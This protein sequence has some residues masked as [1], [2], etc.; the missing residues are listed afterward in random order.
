M[1]K[2][3]RWIFFALLVLVGVAGWY[4]YESFIPKTAV[5]P[6]SRGTITQAVPANV[7]VF[8]EANQ[9]IKSEF[10]GRVIKSTVKRGLQV[11]AG[12]VL[13]DLDTRE[14][15]LDIQ[16]IEM[17]YKAA[18]DRIA[19]GSPL[20][21]ELA[22]S[23]ETERINKRLF[24][25]GRLAQVEL[26]RMKRSIEGL[27]DRM[28]L[29]EIANQQLLANFEN[30]LALKKLQK[31]KMQI[32]APFDGTITEITALNGS[33]VSGGMPMAR[34]ISRE[35]LVQAQISEENF[36]GIRAGLTAN[37]QFLGY[38]ARLFPATIEGVLPSADERT[39]RYI[40]FLKV[41]IP[42]EQLMPD[43]TGEASIT[44]AQKQNVLLAPSRGLAG[45]AVYVVKN[46]HAMLT[47]IVVGLVGLNST[48]VESGVNEGDMVI[49]QDTASIRNGQLV[50]AVKAK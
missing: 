7:V 28:K 32:T 50:R 48:E 34:I 27:K 19:L 16:R 20:R 10:A 8:A 45:H 31:E 1:Q 9:E 40:A 46:G 5:R 43:L 49:S 38:G 13:F 30:T 15:D 41:D 3:I 21:F 6:I 26:D 18:K 35:R 36:A 42:E 11:K 23:E 22:A 47:P 14:L 39:K 37:V 33:L 17:D 25:Q 12:D 24:D 4:T 29:E 44:V 2:P